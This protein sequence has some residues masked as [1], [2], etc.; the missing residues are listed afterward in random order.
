MKEKFD[1]SEMIR[2]SGKE[3]MD[4]IIKN[5]DQLENANK[6]KGIALD[7]R[8]EMIEHKTEAEK[9]LSEDLELPKDEADIVGLKI[10]GI[11]TSCGVPI[12][13]DGINKLEEI[14]AKYS[15][16]PEVKKMARIR[17]DEAIEETNKN[18]VNGTKYAE[19]LK[20]LEEIENTFFTK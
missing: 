6:P 17:L 20:D 4:D 18:L 8:P 5:A 13:K 9:N 7:K 15:K 19:K 3:L 2:K 12:A 10:E 14:F 1:P 16:Y 11:I